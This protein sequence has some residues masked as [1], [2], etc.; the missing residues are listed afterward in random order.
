VSPQ[1]QAALIS[2]LGAL[3][4]LLGWVVAM[5]WL[6]MMLMG[7]PEKAWTL[8][9]WRWWQERGLRRWQRTE[10]VLNLPSVPQPPGT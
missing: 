4:Y 6:Y 5:Q 1:V 7:T 2:E 8:Q 9:A 10:K 3:L